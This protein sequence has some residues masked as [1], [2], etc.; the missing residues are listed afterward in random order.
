[1]YKLAKGEWD[2]GIQK[3]RDMKVYE[4]NGYHYKK[5]LSII[6]KSQWLS[7]LSFESGK[8]EVRC[9]DGRLIMIKANEI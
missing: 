5:I 7:E 4:S 1:M 3:Y 8:I 6:L 2:Y 9:E